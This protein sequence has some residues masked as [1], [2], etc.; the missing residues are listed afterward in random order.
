VSPPASPAG[1]SAPQHLQVLRWFFVDLKR[2]LVGHTALLDGEIVCL[3]PEAVPSSTTCYGAAGGGLFSTSTG[4]SGERHKRSF[5]LANV[6]ELNQLPGNPIEV[7]GHVDRLWDWGV[8]FQSYSEP[9]FAGPHFASL[10]GWIVAEDRRG[11]NVA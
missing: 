9:L 8:S 6:Q 4:S 7:F 10:A 3:D 1:F 5:E 11:E 2:A